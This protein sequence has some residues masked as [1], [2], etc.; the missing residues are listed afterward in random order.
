MTDKTI[1]TLD[2]ELTTVGANDLIGVWDV[3][4]AQYKKAKRSNVVGATI[5]GG[6]T[7][8]LGGYTLTVPATGT[9]ALRGADNN[10]SAAQTMQAGINVGVA[11][12]ALI[13]QTGGVV[14]QAIE[15]N[16]I[17][18]NGAL[19]VTTANTA[20]VIIN[21]ATDGAVAIVSVAG[22]AGTV[23][24]GSASIFTGASGTA[25]R[26]N[27]YYSSGIGVVIQNLRGSTVTV[28]AFV[29]F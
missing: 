11:A 6:G 12:S 20:L 1:N 14:R 24:A 18:N 23:I 26:L 15:T 29:V 25:S 3:A 13:R 5:T 28:S 10:F 19:V 16:T 21:D 27:I 7:I 17:A 22:G 9:A 4:A 8:A 2:T